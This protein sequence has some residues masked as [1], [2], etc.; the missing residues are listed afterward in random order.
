MVGTFRVMI[1]Q[2]ITMRANL[3]QNITDAKVTIAG[4]REQIVTTREDFIL[5]KMFYGVN[6]TFTMPDLEAGEGVSPGVFL[7]MT[8][9]CETYE[10]F[11][12][13]VQY[14]DDNLLD[15]MSYVVAT[16]M[17]MEP[18]ITGISRTEAFTL[19]YLF[20]ALGSASA[21]F[22]AVFLLAPFRA[23]GSCVLWPTSFLFLLMGTI[24]FPTMV[25]MSDTCGGLE[26][27]AYN[28][29]NKDTHLGLSV[30]ELL[31]KN[32]TEVEAYLGMIPFNFS[33]SYEYPIKDIKL[34]GIPQIVESYFGT[35]PAPVAGV[36]SIDGTITEI[37]NFAENTTV[38]LI[39]FAV[40]QVQELSGEIRPG[41]N[42]HVNNV[43]RLADN[44][45]GEIFTS[46]GEL[47]GCAR[48]NEAYFEMKT[49]FCCEF[50]VMVYWMA[51]SSVVVG[52]TGCWG[53]CCIG[54][55]TRSLRH[56]PSLPEA[57]EGDDS[58]DV[59][60]SMPRKSTGDKFEL[61][62]RPPKQPNYGATKVGSGNYRP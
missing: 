12:K 57:G 16:Q 18:V 30:S 37:G 25:I 51:A 54:C 2:L 1:D 60:P 48:V 10:C 22:G 53:I 6:S 45:V 36:P 62:G 38:G 17:D 33:H 31:I 43:K 3:G 52:C 15:V 13:A 14:L 5:W 7:N 8:A 50:V 27:A 35:C 59:G 21:I 29:V 9:D 34:P 46:T 24:L 42:Q 26:H 47:V 58:P 20:T 4:F 28:I 61:D 40:S 23:L 32:V 56:M 49:A 55:T 44:E 11:Q 39:N 41:L 19:L